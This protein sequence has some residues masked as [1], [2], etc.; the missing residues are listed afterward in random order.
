MYARGICTPPEHICVYARV[1]PCAAAGD[2]A[3]VRVDAAE[4]TLHCGAGGP[5]SISCVS[6]SVSGSSLPSPQSPRRARKGGAAAAAALEEPPRPPHP[7]MPR[8]PFQQPQSFAL[9]GVVSDLH[10][11][12]TAAF[13]AATAQACAADYLLEGRDVTVLCCGEQ[14]SGKTSTAFGDGDEPGLCARVFLALFA[15]MSTSS[16]SA[17]AA[18][19][20]PWGRPD[21][22]DSAPATPAAPTEAAV[23]ASMRHEVTLSCLLLQG[24]CVVDLLA[25]V[26]AGDVDLVNAFVAAARPTSSS[27]PSPSSPPSPAFSTAPGGSATSSSTAGAAAASSTPFIAMDRHGEVV[28]RGVAQ[29]SCGSANEA[30]TLVH[31]CRRAQASRANSFGHVIV[32]V[33]VLAEEVDVTEE[34]NEVAAVR[35]AHLHLVDLASVHTT[36]TNTSATTTV[37]VGS[38][39]SSSLSGV[40]APGG[41]CRA[42]EAAV[43]PS[44]IALR[45]VIVGLV[46][47]AAREGRR[48]VGRDT[49][50]LTKSAA[51]SSSA[52]YFSSASFLQYRQCKLT[53]L[54]KGYLGGACHTVVI[55]HVRSEH[56]HLSESLTT[57]RLARQLLCVP[58]QSNAHRTPDSAA[59]VRQL[60]RQVA[61]LQS[62]VRMQVE[63]NRRNALLAAEALRRTAEEKARAGTASTAAH[64]SRTKAGAAP[65]ASSSSRMKCDRYDG[66][67]DA[68]ATEAPSPPSPPSP[69]P[70]PMSPASASLHVSVVDFIAGRLP[71]LPVTTI[72]EMN[73]CF[74][75]L[76]RQVVERDMRLCA[77]MADLRAARAGTVAAAFWNGTAAGTSR[78][79]SSR[80]SHL[81]SL[82]KGAFS[83][84]PAQERQRTSQVRHGTENALTDAT[85]ERHRSPS[86]KSG[87]NS[88]ASSASS[89]VNAGVTTSAGAGGRLDQTGLLEELSP[90]W[91]TAD[92]GVGYGSAP[93]PSQETTTATAAAA[94]AAPRASPA[95]AAPAGR[96]ASAWP[97]SPNTTAVSWMLSTLEEATETEEAAV[98]STAETREGTN[99]AAGRVGSAAEQGGAPSTGVPA[100][101]STPLSLRS[102]LPS[103]ERVRRTQ[104]ADARRAYLT[105]LSPAPTPPQH[106]QEQPDAGSAAAAAAAG[107]SLPLSTP[108]PPKSA[109]AIAFDGYVTDTA[110]GRQLAHFVR[111]D[112]AAVAAL[113]QRLTTAVAPDKVTAAKD[114]YEAAAAQLTRRRRT[115]LNSFEAWYSLQRTPERPAITSTTSKHG[116]PPLNGMMGNEARGGSGDAA[117]LRWFS[118]GGAATYHI[119]RLRLRPSSSMPTATAHTAPASTSSPFPATVDALIHRP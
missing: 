85:L 119:P 11:A 87:A 78:R 13:L 60:Q 114:A 58:E 36:S 19:G 112:E 93:A 29:R 70:W 77:A 110:E 71:M 43:R 90:T 100:T 2:V 44:L 16:S 55:A 1:R 89:P 98:S 42:E 39:G 76:R 52:G 59:Q 22:S 26:G 103:G 92:C 10:D 21:A 57:L 35:H 28:I 111:Q 25:E 47:A 116:A 46:D 64:A 107:W 105:S 15:A 50:P 37:A 3:C 14:G 20:V 54:L 117:A 67:V 6:S 79:S 88:H 5:S 38:N 41:R 62:D 80:S 9:D 45:A 96:Q 51:V 106:P 97:A 115:L 118:A 53:V 94:A 34:G 40:T 61:T 8:R 12:D 73:T 24:E 4:H 108:A 84:S 75:L 72:E 63:L 81:S 18:V 7:P 74:E 30:I 99:P 104:H 31:R 48:Q 49:Q 69:F 82:A 109:E 102:P 101:T 91:V 86:Q 23:M 113:R 32:M 17:A 95:R 27:L 65:S 66:P 33:D 83:A 68:A 56:A